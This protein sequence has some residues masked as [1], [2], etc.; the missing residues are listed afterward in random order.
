MS[1]MLGSQDMP[2]GYQHSLDAS[3]Q[4]SMAGSWESFGPFAV[5]WPV[6]AEASAVVDS[7]AAEFQVLRGSPPAGGKPRPAGVMWLPAVAFAGVVAAFAAAV[8]A[9][10]S[11]EHSSQALIWVCQSDPSAP[12]GPSRPSLSAA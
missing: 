6:V 8:I 1:S 7:W 11:W 12:F 2:Q 4:N 3:A 10:G 9:A 5:G